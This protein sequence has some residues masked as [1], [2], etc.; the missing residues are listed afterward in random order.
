MAINHYPL[1]LRIRRVI[2]WLNKYSLT[3]ALILT[4]LALIIYLAICSWLAITSEHNIAIMKERQA[5]FDQI[6]KESNSMSE[7]AWKRLWIYHGRPAAVIYEP[8]KTP[9][10]INK[11][12]QRC[13]FV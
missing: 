3:I 10:Y 6:N 13:K 11:V 12:G 4:T 8:G 1:C 9:W 5:Y 2:V 7:R